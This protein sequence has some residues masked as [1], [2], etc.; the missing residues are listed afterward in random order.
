MGMEDVAVASVFAR[1]RLVFSS[2]GVLPF[3]CTTTPEIQ[4]DSKRGEK[5]GSS[6]RVRSNELMRGECHTL[7][8]LGL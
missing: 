3:R 5:F 4:P 8:G 1:G 7:F 2:G 6:L